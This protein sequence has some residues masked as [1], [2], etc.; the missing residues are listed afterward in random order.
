GRGVAR[1]TFGL[2]TSHGPMLSIPA[3][4]W[5]DRVSADRENP[6]HFFKGK[7][8]TFDQLVD[9]QR[10]ARLADQIT[11]QVCEERH[12]RCQKAIR[13]L[14]DFF[15]SHR[16]DVALVVGNDQ[17]EV[18]TGDHVPAFAVFWGDYVEGHP[19]TPEFLAKLNRGVARAEADRTPPVYTRYP[20]V[21]GLGRH[22]IEQMMS[23]GFDVSQLTRLPVGEIVVNSA[24]HAYGF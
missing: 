15:E 5:A 7:T 4:Y 1:I 21:P 9:L 8:Y 12:A 3:E 17:M 22:I 16:P 18:F 10:P 23:A 2:G 19:R 24:P 13:E 11:A 6:R 14:G 20:C